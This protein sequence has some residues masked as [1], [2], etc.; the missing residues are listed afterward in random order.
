MD[1][2]NQIRVKGALVFF[3]VVLLG[4]CSWHYPEYH[5]DPPR[6]PGPGLSGPR[7]PTVV[8]VSK[9]DTYYSIARRY[10]VKPAKLLS[11]NHARPPFTIYPGDKLLV[12]RPKVHVVAKDDTLSEI[13]E[14]YRTRQ[15][16]LARINDIEKPDRIAVGQKIKL[17]KS[18]R[19]EARA[20][21]CDG[22]TPIPKPTSGGQAWRRPPGA[23]TIA[24]RL[25]WPLRGRIISSYGRKSK[26]LVNEG[27]NIAARSGEPVKAADS[28]TVIYRGNLI[29]GYGRLMLVRHS[30]TLVTAYAHLKSYAVQKGDWVKRG[31]VIGRVGDSGNVTSPQLHFEVRHRARSVDPMQYLNRY[32]S[33]M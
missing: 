24:N 32:A 22:R 4:S 13:A 16:K 17:P 2:P 30:D 9:G 15:K 11:V 28:G 14:H 27:I 26:G 29:P 6:K 25:S 3:G 12:P 33:A 23:G 19:R 18:G 1:Q 5:D 7:A 8:I 10:G 31:E 21:C 20:Y